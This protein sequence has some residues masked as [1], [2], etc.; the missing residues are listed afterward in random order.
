MPKYIVINEN[1]LAYK[2]E[3]SPFVGVLAGSVVRGGHDPKN[4]SIAISPLDVI[5][6]ATKEDFEFYNVSPDGHLKENAAPIKMLRSEVNDLNV[7][8]ALFEYMGKRCGKFGVRVKDLDS[9]EVVGLKIWDMLELA[10]K[11]YKEIV[12]KNK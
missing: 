10:L 6:Q 11:E 9:D 3:G 12:E 4:G 8:T 7:E 1:T 2:I 5:R